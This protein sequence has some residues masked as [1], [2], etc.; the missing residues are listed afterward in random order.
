MTKQEKNDSIRSHK[1]G[2]N[3]KWDDHAKWAMSKMEAETSHIGMIN[4][5]SGTSPREMTFYDEITGAR[6]D[7]ELVIAAR[8]EEMARTWRGGV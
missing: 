5:V 3:K 4:I 2:G 6:L 8:A 7:T 1:G